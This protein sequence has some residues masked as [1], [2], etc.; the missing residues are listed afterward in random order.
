MSEVEENVAVVLN[1]LRL[2]S[3]CCCWVHV[4]ITLA[5]QIVLADAESV[6]NF[7]SL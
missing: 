6:E 4:S 7:V 5:A 3:L 1:T 2:C